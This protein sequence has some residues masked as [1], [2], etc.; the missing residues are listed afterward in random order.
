MSK[1][2]FCHGSQWIDADTATAADFYANHSR[3]K[4]TAYTVWRK[5]GFWNYQRRNDLSARGT[6]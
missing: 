4:L 6:T 5:H 3:P 2:S 1:R